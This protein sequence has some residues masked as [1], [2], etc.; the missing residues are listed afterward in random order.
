M[1]LKYL[2]C[3]FYLGGVFASIT[4]AMLAISMSGVAN[5]SEAIAITLFIASGLLTII[6]SLRHLVHPTRTRHIT[7]YLSA[8]LLL[9]IPY[10]MI[11]INGPIRL[12]PGQVTFLSIT[13]AYQIIFILIFTLNSQFMPESS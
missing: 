9:I 1:Y 11:A 2:Y 13:A 6:T 10:I 4:L 8:I 12:E 5:A 3:T 7:A